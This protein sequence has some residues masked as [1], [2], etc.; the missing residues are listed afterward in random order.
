MNLPLRLSASLLALGLVTGVAYAKPSIQHVLLISV[1]GLHASDLSRYVSGHPQSAMAKLASHGLT[2][3][4]AMT[5]FPS[6]SFPGLLSLVTGG[7]PRTTGIWYDAAFG[8]DLAEAKECKP[9]M[10]SDGAEYD[11]SE[12]IDV[13]NGSVFTTIDPSKLAVNPKSCK[14]I[15][16]HSLLRVNTVFEV[17]KN[18]GYRTAWAD[19]HPAYD[20]VNGPS[21]K[22]VDDLFVPEITV[23]DGE[24]ATS[25]ID[26][27]IAYD[28]TKVQAVINELKGLDSAGKVKI[29]VPVI[30]GMNFQAVS[31]GQKLKGNGYANANG[32]PS[33]G[34]AKSLD[35][36]DASLAQISAT[37]EAEKLATNTLVIISAKHGQS[38]IDPAKRR[39]VDSKALKATLNSVGKDVIAS[40]TTDDVALVW[41]SDKSKTNDVV[42]ALE[43]KKSDLAINSIISGAALAKDYADPAKDPRAPDLIIQP[44]TGVIYTKPTA[45]KLAEHGGGTEEDR[46]VALLVA[47]PALTAKTLDEAVSTTQV[48]PSILM[49]LGLKPSHLM[50][51]RGEKTQ[52]L[53]EL[54]DTAERQ[55]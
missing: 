55:K 54:F 33:E 16:P 42:K 18:F 49:I 45:S 26:K 4:K 31:V 52:L 46:H 32:E 29:G 35:A 1:D 13:K 37:L 7:S 39:I 6:D 11:Y 9:G 36:V 28:G 51:V 17:I 30:L 22:G 2:Y 40:V 34:L 14:P 41:L 27:V 38:P 23:L 5:S 24:D 10:K 25:S 44:E 20:L 8:H 12:E 3:S 47:N 19:K 43:A 50:A 53:P 15:Y 21:G 48:A